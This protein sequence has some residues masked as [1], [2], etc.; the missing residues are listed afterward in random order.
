MSSF[1]VNCSRMPQTYCFES[2]QYAGYANN[3]SYY[4]SMK[5]FTYG[6]CSVKNLFLPELIGIGC[7]STSASNATFYANTFQKIYLPKMTNVYGSGTSNIFTNCNDLTEFHFGKANQTAVEALA[8]YSTLWG[9]GAGNATVYF[10]LINTITVGGVDYT[11]D[12]PDYE[13]DYDGGTSYYSWKNGSDII[14]T[15]EPYTPAVN[16]SVYTKSGDTYTVSGTITAV[17]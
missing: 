10:D 4:G 2:L 9:R 13:I 8:G 12:G 14:Y 6:T 3:T 1:L 5:Q 7:S 11:R 16:D 17:A 15:T